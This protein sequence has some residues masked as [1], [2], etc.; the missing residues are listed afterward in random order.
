MRRQV[1]VSP[2]RKKSLGPPHPKLIIDVGEDF[3]NRKDLDISSLLD[4]SKTTTAETRT[5][6]LSRQFPKLK[7]LTP[8]VGPKRSS[9]TFDRSKNST[10]TPKGPLKPSVFDFGGTPKSSVAVHN[11]HK[12]G[13]MQKPDRK[14]RQVTALVSEFVNVK[15]LTPRRVQRFSSPRKTVENILRAETLTREALGKSQHTSNQP[16]ALLQSSNT[17]ATE[18]K[19]QDRSLKGLVTQVKELSETDAELVYREHLF[20]TFNALHFIKT[21]STPSADQLY[22]KRATLPKQVLP[23]KKTMIFDLDETLVHCCE[24]HQLSSAD[25]VLPV[26]LPSGEVINVR[27]MQAGINIRPHVQALLEAAR[28]DFEV[29]VFTASHQCYADVVIDYLDPRRELIEHRFYRDSCVV[30]DGCFIKDLRIFHE[31]K[32]K[33]LTLVDNSVL[34]FGLQL[35]NGVPIVSW[36]NDKADKELMNLIDYLKQIRSVEDVRVVHRST[37]NLASFY[38]DFVSEMQ[39]EL[40]KGPKVLRRKRRL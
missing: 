10:V 14:V 7:S 3:S 39:P 34:S 8:R 6:S 37:F 21:M 18:P 33:D 38:D 2:K 11:I 23:N 32:L 9:E 25:V 4:Y 29:F 19:H 22:S 15:P 12:P 35:D 28:A 24:E 1:T 26:R 40:P 27:N 36:Y 20:S 30:V 16:S 31:R 5:K 17:V 13:W